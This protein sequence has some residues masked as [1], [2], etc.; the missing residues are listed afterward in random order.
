MENKECLHEFESVYYGSEWEVEC[1]YCG[2][3]VSQ[4]YNTEDANKVVDRML[5]NN[6]IKKQKTVWKVIDLKL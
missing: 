3:N 5:E 2:K 6:R 4:I 1:K